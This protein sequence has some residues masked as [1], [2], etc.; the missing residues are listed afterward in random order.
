LTDEY[1]FRLTRAEALGIIMAVDPAKRVD[2]DSLI[3]GVHNAAFDHAFKHRN[4]T[5]DAAER[6]ADAKALAASCR[7]VL[8]KLGVGKRAVEWRS[9]KRSLGAGALYTAGPAAL[10]AIKAVQDLERWAE[11]IKKHYEPKA[12]KEG[13][14]RKKERQAVRLGPLFGAL[15]TVYFVLWEDLPAIT[16]SD[17]R[18]SVREAE[19]AAASGG[20]LAA[21]YESGTEPPTRFLRFLCELLPLLAER[22]I[23]DLPELTDQ[24][25]E[26]AV[27]RWRLDKD[28]QR[29]AESI[30][31]A[32]RQLL[33]EFREE[34]T[35]LT[36]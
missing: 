36:K 22:G 8:V 29:T 16:R 2:V 35:R 21:S 32:A 24:A 6:V 10:D 3:V 1:D 33:A 20:V 9:L 19:E 27:R 13:K 14:R 4:R 18:G 23:D 15:E 12:A 28:G 26:Q 25:I 34:A 11:N 17:T 5:P 30:E 7:D 31:V